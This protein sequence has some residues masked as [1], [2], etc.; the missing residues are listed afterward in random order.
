MEQMIVGAMK[1]SLTKP[2][3]VKVYTYVINHL[4]MC[5]IDNLITAM[6]TEFSVR[7]HKGQI[8]NVLLILEHDSVFQINL[9]LHLST[10]AACWSTSP[11]SCYTVL[12]S[13]RYSLA[14]CGPGHLTRRSIYFILRKYLNFFYIFL[15]QNTFVNNFLFMEHYL[16]EAGFF[17]CMK[18]QRY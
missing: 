17:L 10:W 7:C 5:G 13:R 11:C 3:Q 15:L 14:C 4:H 2:A 16:W 6:V 9:A 18:S 1:M 8:V 12:G